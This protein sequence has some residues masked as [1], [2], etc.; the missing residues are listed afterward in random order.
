M[1][2]Y[3][4]RELLRG[5]PSIHNPDRGCSLR[6][7]GVQLALAR[8]LLEP[9]WTQESNVAPPPSL[10]SAHCSIEG[11]A[12]DQPC[13]AN[14]RHKARLASMNASTRAS[15]YADEGRTIS[16]LASSAALAA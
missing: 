1:E 3:Y 13:L 12:T 15:C 14:D 10:S 7:Y 2:A 11:D 6:T 16:Q 8:R 4:S 9:V 5:S